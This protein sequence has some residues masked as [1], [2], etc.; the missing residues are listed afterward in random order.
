MTNSSVLGSSFRD[1]SGFL[2]H[3]DGM[4]YRQV[5][6]HYRPEYDLL[7]SSGLY[8][9]LTGKGMLVHHEEV[10]QKP[11]EPPLAYKVIRPEVIEFIS[12]P[13][14]WSFS[15]L[16]DAAMRTLAIQTR[17]LRKGMS[18]KD[19]SAYNIQFQ[20]GSATLIDTLSFESYQE[21]QPWVA[22]KQFC[23]HF[24]APLA[25]MAYRDVRLS[26]LLRVYLDGIPLDLASCLLPARTRLNFGL[27]THLHLHASFQRKYSSTRVDS[28]KQT[29]RMT[30]ASLEG[31]IESLKAVVRGLKWNP[32]G[33]EWGS[34]YDESAGHY[35]EKALSHKL[36]IVEKFIE[37]IEPR[38]AWDL[39]ANTGMF[40]RAS[41]RHG[42]PT[43]A[44]DIDP[45]AVERNYLVCKENRETNL[46]PLVLDLTNPSPAIGWDHC[47]RMSL[48]ER[49]PADMVLALALVHHLA[50]A[51]NV[52]L[53]RLAE[54]FHQAG[55]W[56]VIEFV[57]KE[58]SQVQVLLASRKDIFPDYTKQGFEVAFMEYFDIHEVVPIR[59]TGRVVYLMEVQSEIREKQKDQGLP[60]ANIL[61]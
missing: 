50:I 15:Q 16:K 48:L 22:Y 41:S 51:N 52:P 53:R 39:G 29:A 8:D 37:K 32:A 21:G 3:S 60:F 28:K 25:L 24:L 30:R 7:F 27:S 12:Y 35:S 19:A 13:Y 10:D 58:D 44:F 38:T 47:E 34:Y 18:L 1:P 20:R 56:L 59:E 31:L 6:L 33:T 5:N 55:R 4:L 49:G 2:F 45:A 11:L 26:Q 23:Q 46:L 14:E 36:E 40:S 57:P 9:E 17:A 61:A 42:I 54:F 43:V